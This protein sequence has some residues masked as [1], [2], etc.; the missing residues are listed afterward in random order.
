MLAAAG[1]VV[2]LPAILVPVAV[3]AASAGLSAV[4]P[5]LVGLG[6]S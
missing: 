4:P 5:C 2:I 3:W 1:S 6:A